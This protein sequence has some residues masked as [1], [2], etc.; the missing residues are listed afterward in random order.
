MPLS[1][2]NAPKRRQTIQCRYKNIHYTT[3]S[4][5][6]HSTRIDAQKEGRKTAARKKCCQKESYNKKP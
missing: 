4:K 5:G 6:T 3:S 1:L 2:A